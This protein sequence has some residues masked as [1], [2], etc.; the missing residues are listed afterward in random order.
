MTTS[1]TTPTTATDSPNGSAPVIADGQVI[2]GA[3]I[4]LECLRREGVDT[5]FG[6]PGGA[7][8]WLYRY[9][10]DFTDIRHILARHEQGATHMADGYA[11]ANRGKAGVVFAT[12][13]PGALNC[14][15]GIATA[16]Y[17][18]VPLVVVTGQVP[19]V[20]VG[21]DAFQESDVIGVTMPIVKHSYLLQSVDEI[22][23]VVR[24]AFH[25]ATSGRP[26][27]VVIDFPKDL[28]NARHPFH[29]PAG[30]VSLRSYNPTTR[31][32]PL[33]IKRAAKLIDEAK[34]PAMLAGRGV[35]IS[36]G[37]EELLELSRKASIPVGWTLLGTGC[38]PVGEELSLHM[39][40]FMGAGYT[41]KAVLGCD[42][43]IMVG[44]RAD[45]R[46]TT[47]LDSFAPQ[48][49][50]IIH[51]DID[52]AEIGKN[53]RPTLPIV[54]DAKQVLGEIAK[55]VAPKRLD[56]WIT[57]IERWKE[58]HPL[59]YRR[60]TGVLQPQDVLLEMYRRCDSDAIVV[61]DVGQNQIWGALWWDFKGSGLYLN[62]G[63]SGTMGFAFP[64]SL[65]ARVGRPDKPV[66]C[67]AGEGG[68]VM[69]MQEL[70]TAV[71]E[72]ID[73][74]VVILNNYCLGMVRQF[75]DDYYEGVRS[76]VDLRVGPDFVKLADAFGMPGWRTD[77][78]E[79]VPQLLDR[80]QRHS[81]PCIG[82]FI[83]DPEANVRPIV[84]L[85]KGL[86]DFVEEIV[87]A[88]F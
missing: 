6:Y 65:G 43:L 36:R 60:N 82:E 64:A 71:Q 76:A 41:N 77:K 55:L 73:V 66:W 86:P 49:E 7:N 85:G 18:S 57:Q 67:I 61:A 11:R 23:R 30:P 19:T 70:A 45:D 75:Q 22:A 50:N 38:Y 9:L 16:Q 81:G 24:E 59:R 68:F 87:E 21:T 35:L 25:I 48:V 28:Q 80:M 15:T 69:T 63:G 20:A 34:R 26:G 32:N 74:K 12:S 88:G 27:V 47:K 14:I 8:L 54:G 46:V 3:E 4:L 53:V 56:S 79:E 42:L 84:P 1:T 17:D 40:G 10:P 83:I 29:W 44:M 78:V 62:S 31:G 5:I 58:E 51:I 39:V 37:E 2:T 52:P 72:N 33:Q 13:G